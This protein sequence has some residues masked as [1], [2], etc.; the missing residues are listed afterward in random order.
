MAHRCHLLLDGR[1]SQRKPMPRRVQ[2]LPALHPYVAHR[3]LVPHHPHPQLAGQHHLP[4]PAPGLHHLADLHTQELS[5]QRAVERQGLLRHLARR[6]AHLDS[7]GLG[8]L[9]VDGRSV[10]RLVDVPAR[11][12]RHHHVL[13]RPDGDVRKARP[14]TAHPKVVGPNT[15]RRGILAA[16]GA[17]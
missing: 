4:A 1:A 5:S 6:H 2:D 8:R 17:R 13:L 9:H 15:D 14:R 11:C 7:H 10:A 12:H 3:D 16:P